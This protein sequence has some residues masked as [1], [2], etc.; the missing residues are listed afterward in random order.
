[1]MPSIESEASMIETS[2]R[3]IIGLFQRQCGAVD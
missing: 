1:L 3:D 2:M